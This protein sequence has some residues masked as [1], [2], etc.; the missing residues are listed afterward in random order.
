M[1]SKLMIKE[2][3][4]ELLQ[5]TTTRHY[6]GGNELKVGDKVA[7]GMTINY[8][9]LYGTPPQEIKQTDPKSFTLNMFVIK[10]SLLYQ[11]YKQV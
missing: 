3:T 2:V 9:N 10:D 5:K 6:G 1:D 11:L 4:E 7:W 8:A